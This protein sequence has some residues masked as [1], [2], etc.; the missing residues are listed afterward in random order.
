[1]IK[2]NLKKKEPSVI[3]EISKKDLLI[4]CILIF[5]ACLAW[6]NILD[7]VAYTMNLDSLKEATIAFASIKL[8]ESM[9]SLA[10]NIP[11]VGAILTPIKEFLQQ[12]SWVM[13][14]SL[15]S[16]GLQK[17]I[18]VAMQSFI[19]N[20]LL[21]FSVFL[22]VLDRLNPVFSSEFANK[23]LKVTL[24]LLFV[25]FAIPFMTFAVTS[26]E[27]STK[28]MQQEVSQERMQKLQEK[29][30]NI[31]ALILDDKK[32][33]EER[34]NKVTIL[35]AKKESLKKDKSQIESEIKTI[36]NDENNRIKKDKNLLEKLNF[37]SSEELN[38]K[39]NEDIINKTKLIEN[40]DKEIKIVEADIDNSSKWFDI[41]LKPKLD[42]AIANM[43]TYLDELFD[44]LI[45]LA[46][47]FLFKNVLFPIG[48]IWALFKLVDRA[49]NTNTED[50][51]K[52]IVNEKIVK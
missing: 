22:V 4:S 33:K 21:S 38:Q 46:I 19:I 29:L 41:S 51:L 44:T 36:K 25:R 3:A 13:L 39:A 34:S 16:L 20:A 24:L 43:K 37:L 8:I 27:S 11:F 28:K 18:I 30:S 17:V 5:F 2:K 49:F 52:K 12:I 42:A 35:E 10:N 7:K 26:I 50:R 47:L 40:I 45:T 9:V 32:A 48:F 14:I 23:L 1:M 31:D 6:I 15:M